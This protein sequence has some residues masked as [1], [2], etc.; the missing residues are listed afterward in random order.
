WSRR[1]RRGFDQARSLAAAFARAGGFELV[2]ALV[3]RRPTRPQ[4][5][6]SR[7]R[8]LHHLDGAFACR[9][10]EAV[11]GQ[12]ILLV[13]DVVTTGAT[14]RAAAR[15]LLAAG[16]ASVH[17]L[18][19]ARTPAPGERVPDPAGKGRPGRRIDGRTV[20]SLY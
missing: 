1:W 10:P 18:A 14:A 5:R 19:A 11:A 15:T 7:G 3:R 16:A 8:R 17:V 2:P 4:V 12:R 13:D 6:R 9:T 20:N